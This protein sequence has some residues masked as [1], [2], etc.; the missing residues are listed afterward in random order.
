ME[1]FKK[2]ENINISHSIFNY[3]GSKVFTDNEG[4][5]YYALKAKDTNKW[6]LVNAE[7]KLLTPFVYDDLGGVVVGEGNFIYMGVVGDYGYRMG[8]LDCFGNVVVEPISECTVIFSDGLAVIEQNGKFGYVD[9]SGNIVIPVIYDSA[10]D[11][12]YGTAKVK[13]NKETF[14]INKKG[15][16]LRKRYFYY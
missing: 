5:K 11:F 2:L 15:E 4:K 14:C 12:S 6:G 13:L 1:E 10:T 8:L 7:G 9:I 16:R 3:N